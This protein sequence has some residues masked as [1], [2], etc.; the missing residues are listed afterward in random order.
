MSSDGLSGLPVDELAQFV[1]KCVRDDPALL[2]RSDFD[3][4]GTAPAQRRGRSIA[5]A[6]GFAGVLAAN[7]AIAIYAL[8][9]HSDAQLAEIT[10]A[11]IH[12]G[13][14]SPQ[15][16]LPPVTS[17]S[18]IVANPASL[19]PIAEGDVPVDTPFIPVLRT[20]STGRPAA[21]AASPTG[22]LPAEL[23]KEVAGEPSAEIIRRET[24][25]TG[26]LQTLDLREAGPT[27][28]ARHQAEPSIAGPSIAGPVE[29]VAAETLPP[30]AAMSAPPAE[31][32]PPAVA[33]MAPDVAGESTV[34]GPVHSTSPPRRRAVYHTYRQPVRRFV[35]YRYNYYPPG[36]P[37]VL[38]QFATTIRRNIYAIFH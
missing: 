38:A 18:E 15:T 19:G 32:S 6:V 31:A 30:R 14:L 1:L 34:P 17:R 7:A 33:G 4:I 2:S 3:A 12:S 5:A 29:A 10:A 37:A 8:D 20:A 36:P 16:G 13:D 28:T 23:Q 26:A 24:P 22:G 27:V 25:G 35:Y 9:H 21:A 11:P